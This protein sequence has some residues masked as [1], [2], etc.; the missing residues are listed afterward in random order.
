[1]PICAS[2]EVRT[3]SN[4]GCPK[5]DLDSIEP[6]A[7][8]RT[9]ERTMADEAQ[10]H[11]GILAKHSLSASGLEE[12]IQRLD[13]FYTAVALG[14][15]RAR[16]TRLGGLRS[17]APWRADGRNRRR[18]RQERRL[19][20]WTSAGRVPGRPRRVPAP[21]R[22]QVAAEENDAARRRHEADP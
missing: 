4:P 17:C 2:G 20:E 21:P 1:V 15:R 18:F 7:P 11:R 9:A 8:P 3:R 14:D 6:N 22:R 5:L 10:A 13:Q 16:H 19:V 12:F